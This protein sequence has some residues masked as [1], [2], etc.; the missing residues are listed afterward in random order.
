MLPGRLPFS[1]ERRHKMAEIS[2][3]ALLQL[4]ERGHAVAVKEFA[5]LASEFYEFKCVNEESADPKVKTVLRNMG[6]DAYDKVLDLNRLAK[7]ENTKPVLPGAE[8]MREDK[9]M[10]CCFE[11]AETM[12]K[13]S[14]L[15]SY[16]D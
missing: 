13:I 15:E 2:R 5:S 3:E 16:D 7:S 12:Y 4:A 14:K 6:C 9:A 11:F 8:Y 1:V 10:D